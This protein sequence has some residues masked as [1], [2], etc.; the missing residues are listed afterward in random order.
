MSKLQNEGNK[1]NVKVSNVNTTS[2]S[3]SHSVAV[4]LGKPGKPGRPS[5]PGIPSEP[6]KA[7]KQNHKNTKQ[8][9]GNGRK[10]TGAEKKRKQKQEIKKGGKK[11][12]KDHND[13]MSHKHDQYEKRVK[14]HKKH[15]KSMKR[16]V[17]LKLEGKAKEETLE[18]KKGA[19]GKGIKAIQKINKHIVKAHA[20]HQRTNYHPSTKQH[21]ITIFNNGIEIATKHRPNIKFAHTWGR[22]KHQDLSY[23]ANG[24]KKKEFH[25]DIS[26]TDE[27]KHLISKHQEL[28]LRTRL[29]LHEH[30]THSSLTARARDQ[31][32]FQR[33]KNKIK[34]SIYSSKSQNQRNV[35]LHM[36]KKLNRRGNGIKDRKTS[37]LTEKKKKL[38]QL[39][40]SQKAQRSR[41]KTGM[42]IE[43]VHEVRKEFKVKKNLT[44]PEHKNKKTVDQLKFKV[45]QTLEGNP[46]L[47]KNVSETLSPFKTTRDVLNRSG[48]NLSQ[49]KN[50][51][52]VTL[53][54]QIGKLQN[55]TDNS[56]LESDF[57][58]GSVPKPQMSS[59]TDWKENLARPDFFEG[60]SLDEF[61]FH[62]LGSSSVAGSSLPQVLMGVGSDF[63][64]KPG[65]ESKAHGIITG[66]GI[67]SNG[68][69][70]GYVS[71]S[72]Y[73][74]EQ[75]DLGAGEDEIEQ[76]GND[77]SDGFDADELTTGSADG[78]GALTSAS[79]TS[80]NVT[81]G[82]GV[83]Q[84]KRENRVKNGSGSKVELSS[85]ESVNGSVVPSSAT[86][87]NRNPNYGQDSAMQKG[88]DIILIGVGRVL[89]SGLGRSSQGFSS[90][91]DAFSSLSDDD[92]DDV[93]GFY[94]SRF[95]ADESF[96]ESAIHQDNDDSNS[97]LYFEKT[98]GK[99]GNDFN[100]FDDREGI[101]SGH[102]SSVIPTDNEHGVF[103]SVDM[104]S[105]STASFNLENFSA[106]S[107]SG[108]H[109]V[110]QGDND[111]QRASQDNNHHSHDPPDIYAGLFPAHS[112]QSSL[113]LMANQVRRPQG[114]LYQY[115][116]RD[117]HIS[118]N[119]IS[120]TRYNDGYNVTDNDK[121]YN[122]HYD[123]SNVL[124]GNGEYS[125]PEDKASGQVKRD[126]SGS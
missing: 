30:E 86:N 43:L 46:L 53:E 10:D 19:T 98:L 104:D 74:G 71:S 28:K 73:L 69:A 100:E 95:G 116:K 7:V 4:K 92:T 85:A 126:F 124:W 32:K 34:K 62:E 125:L 110:A 15:K 16:R 59:D 22:R 23:K 9:Q 117:F 94:G 60:S 81:T 50:L 51:G 75:G 40:E 121:G 67:R 64:L 115:N 113:N 24:K 13:R 120:Q 2:P 38:I 70:S 102:T 8:A 66:S 83:M 97:G 84:K 5:E 48:N 119:E 57:V 14:K 52:N 103:S 109:L 3:G 89:K 82:I 108:I 88:H 42:T 31:G 91:F 55:N 87:S 33:L 122:S 80:R 99:E 111:E 18:K 44:L 47:K 106:D 118:S 114:V 77:D 39:A 54:S 68:P 41:K 65:N 79:K 37:R 29:R 58:A 27:L 107:G 101:V 36:R 56:T 12:P 6:V 26:M 93:S 20:T 49:I 78:F 1:T 21:W 76:G 105:R 45:T 25:E 17:Y 61:G 90:G 96:M 35:G 63:L 123:E 112:V 11:R 72:S